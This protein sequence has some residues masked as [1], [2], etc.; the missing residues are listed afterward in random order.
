MPYTAG[1]R[2]TPLI[3]VMAAAFAIPA[4][5]DE[6]AVARAQFTSAVADREPVDS[7]DSVSVSIGR[8]RFFT[9]LHGLEGRA[10]VHRWEHGGQV[11]AEV[12]IPV[13]ADR[14][15]AWSSKRLLPAWTGIWQV[16][17]IAD[18]GAVLGTWTLEVE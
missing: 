9:E 3:A 17:V 18:D 14:W 15:R 5:A 16:S 4:V 10:A 8:V 2:T 13:G 11:R 7:L 1:V 12:A 6:P